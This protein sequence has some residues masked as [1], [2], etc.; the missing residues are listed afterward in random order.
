MKSS[1][2]PKLAGKRFGRWKVIERAPNNGR[3]SAWSCVCTCGTERRV[4]SE[5]LLRG[6]SSS[7]GCTRPARGKAKQPRPV[8]VRREPQP[9]RMSV[10][11]TIAA[12]FRADPRDLLKRLGISV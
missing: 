5:H 11:E 12:T 9:A 10:E 4:L 7:C 6:D 2:A 3:R 8:K 1:R